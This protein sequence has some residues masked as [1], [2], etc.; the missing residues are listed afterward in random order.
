MSALLLKHMPQ[1][2]RWEHWRGT[3][4]EVRPY[5]LMAYSQAIKEFHN[6]ISGYYLNDDICMMVEQLCHPFPEHR[7]HPRNIQSKGS[8]YNLERYISKLDLLKRKAELKIFKDGC[9][10]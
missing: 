1:N 9:K 3:F 4:E 8:N 2:L 10:N 6:G 5:L 7:G